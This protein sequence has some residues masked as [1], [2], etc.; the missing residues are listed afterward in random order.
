V[1]ITALGQNRNITYIGFA[2]VPVEHSELG[3]GVGVTMLDGV[4]EATVCK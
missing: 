1:R 2:N 4:L 3:T